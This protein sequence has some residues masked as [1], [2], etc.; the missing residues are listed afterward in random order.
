[1]AIDNSNR[2]PAPAR[3]DDAVD[4]PYRAYVI[5][6]FVAGILALNYPLLSLYDHILLLWGIPLLYLY[7]FL[8]WL[9]IIGLTALVMERISAR[10]EH[11]TRR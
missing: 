3:K 7:L 1:M 2:E 11:Q 6:L 5:V 8:A 9:T 4:H 10:S